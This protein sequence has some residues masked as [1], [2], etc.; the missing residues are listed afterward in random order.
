MSPAQY[1]FSTTKILIVDDDL[2]ARNLVRDVLTYMG[3]NCVEAKGGEEAVRWLAENSVDLVL[4]DI[5]MPGMDGLETL[6]VIREMQPDLPVIMLTGE[7]KFDNVI[8]AMRLGAFDYVTKPFQL[9]ILEKS[10]QRALDQQGMVRERERLIQELQQAKHYLEDEVV[11]RSGLATIGSLAA[12]VA[13]EF[14]NLIGAMIGYAE[15]AVRSGDERLKEQT[16][17]VVLKSCARAKQITGNLL[18]YARRQRAKPQMCRLS[19]L[20]DNAL[21]LLERDFRKRNIKVVREVTEA[22]STMCDP[23]QIAQVFF[24]VL[25]NAK[26]AMPEGGNIS[27]RMM[28]ANHECAISIADEGVGIPPDVLD[29]IFEPFAARGCVAGKERIGLGLS[30]AAMILDDHKGRIEIDSEVGRGT[31][32]TIHLPIVS[33]SPVAN[34]TVPESGKK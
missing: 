12:G 6:R 29:R 2:M 21:A 32:V 15:L 5:V 31:T 30:V 14:N 28:E 7:H 33:T 24:G 22:H 26:E 19:E 4:L 3:L 34:E 9:P 20:L 11:R 8:E 16:I 25:D 23:G 13:H 17:Q 1:N 27:V 18:V 10:V